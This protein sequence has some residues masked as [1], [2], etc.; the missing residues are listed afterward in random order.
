MIKPLTYSSTRTNY[1]YI[2]R[3]DTEILP[4]MKPHASREICNPKFSLK[5]MSLYAECMFP[6][7]KPGPPCLLSS[8]HPFEGQDCTPGSVTFVSSSSFGFPAVWCTL[9]QVAILLS[10]SGVKA[11]AWATTSLLVS[12]TLSAPFPPTQSNH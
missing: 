7:Y 2:Q 12:P 5:N 4:N 11:Q 10:L 6:R 1:C 8:G 9:H 3:R